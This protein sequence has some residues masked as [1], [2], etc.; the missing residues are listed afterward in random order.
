MGLIDSAQRAAAEAIQDE[1]VELVRTRSW[2]LAR[3][4]SDEL[5]HF[6]TNASATATLEDVRRDKAYDAEDRVSRYLNL[7]AVKAN[8]AAPANITY[9]SCSAEV[10]AVMGHDVMKSVA[11]LVPFGCTHRGDCQAGVC[12]DMLCC[13][14]G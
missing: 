9:A 5:L 3:A 2:R 10:D 8:V 1:V 14:H 4:R 7:P 6:I 11:K 13:M 12:Q